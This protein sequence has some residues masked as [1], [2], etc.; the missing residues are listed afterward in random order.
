MKDKFNKIVVLGDVHGRD[1]WK[2]IVD[3]NSD[4]DLF[5]FLGDYVSTHDDIS[6]EKQL[7]NLYKILRFKEENPDKVVLLRGNHDM[8][9][10]GYSWAEC[11]GLFRPV[12]NELSISVVR[13]RFLDN[14]QWVFEYDGYVF[15]HAG[16]TERWFNDMKESHGI[17]T[18]ADINKLEPSEDF[19]F[20]PCKMSDYYGISQTQGPTW[21]RPQT[22]MEYA[23]KGHNYVVGHTPVKGI[24]EVKLYLENLGDP[25]ATEFAEK[26]PKIWL[27]DNLPNEYLIIENGEF[28]PT[29]IC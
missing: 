1:I 6:S 4:A 18:V 2:K 14:T 26:M 16:L 20:R 19:G 3:D 7:S 29:K 27:C 21:V 22:L 11:S 5:I 9:H 28:K 13:E 25:E 15:S 12:L 10:L 23:L 8:Q 24:K 17:E